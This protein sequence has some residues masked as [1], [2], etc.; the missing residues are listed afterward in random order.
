MLWLEATQNHTDDTPF[1][2]GT[3]FYY[4][5]FLFYTGPLSLNSLT[6]TP[7]PSPVFN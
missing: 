7:E 2:H 6:R 4:A 5:T 3:T 1:L